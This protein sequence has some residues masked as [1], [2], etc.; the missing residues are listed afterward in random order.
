MFSYILYWLPGTL[1]DLYIALARV[2]KLEVECPERQ[3]VFAKM[4]VGYFF[5]FEVSKQVNC[6]RCKYTRRC[7][8]CCSHVCDKL[9]CIQCSDT[10]SSACVYG[11]MH[12][13]PAP[14]DV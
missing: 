12:S 4:S 1:K 8:L 11:V 7:R 5:N 10:E 2:A 14:A 13:L 9:V 6:C 3:M